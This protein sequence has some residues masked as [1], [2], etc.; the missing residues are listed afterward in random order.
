MLENSCI[1]YHSFE[2]I[3]ANDFILFDNRIDLWEFSLEQLPVLA[4][5]LLS[6]DE[7][8]RAARFYFPIH[9]QKYIIA[10]ATLRLILAR[11]LKQSPDKLLFNY[12]KY[13]KPYINDLEFNLSHSGNLVLVAVGKSFP[14]GVDLEEVKDKAYADLASKIFTER[15]LQVFAGLPIKM[16]AQFFYHIWT[17]KEAFVKACGLGLNFPLDKLCV[18]IDFAEQSLITEEGKCWQLLPFVPKV[19]YRASLCCEPIVKKYRYIRV[20][21]LDLLFT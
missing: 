2:Q 6:Q 10:R 14:L 12:T 8:E 18:N 7:K 9:Q 15:E 3:N 21:N 17:Q 4:R 11:Y 13:G 20:K 19:A 16:Q 1:L 5:N